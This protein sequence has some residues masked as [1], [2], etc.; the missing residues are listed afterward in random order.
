M[1]RIILLDLQWPNISGQHSA[2]PEHSAMP[3][4]KTMNLQFGENHCQ[5]ILYKKKLMV[6]YF[7]KIRGDQCTCQITQAR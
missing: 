7:K 1:T 2:M 5:I 3:G 6:K 4:E